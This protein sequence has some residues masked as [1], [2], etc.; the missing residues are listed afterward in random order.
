MALFLPS[1]GLN[2]RKMY[3]NLLAV[4]ISILRVALELHVKEQCQL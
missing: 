3:P 1:A 2:M 4:T